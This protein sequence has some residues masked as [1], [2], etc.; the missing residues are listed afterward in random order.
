MKYLLDTNILLRLRQK[1]H[2]MHLDA[3][4]AVR[5]LKRKQQ[6]LCIFPQN[7]VE[8]WVVAT[9]PIAVN[10]LGLSFPL[11]LREIKLLKTLFVLYEDNSDIFSQWEKLIQKYQVMGKQAHDTRLVAAMISHQID[12][13]LTFNTD[14]F[15]KYSEVTA[16]E[17][18]KIK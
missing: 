15:K 9:R 2:P 13:V 12:H 18:K 4:N 3:F 1:N 7:L 5:L 10:G 6:A 14:D 16:V 8:F 17:P 11:A